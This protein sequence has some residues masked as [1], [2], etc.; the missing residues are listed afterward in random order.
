MSH[1]GLSMDWSHKVHH[2]LPIQGSYPIRESKFPDYFLT[3]SQK[4]Q[5]FPDPHFTYLQNWAT[6][7]EPN[8]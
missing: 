1:M 5:L 4:H 2:Q 8:R 6:K 7:I 3:Y